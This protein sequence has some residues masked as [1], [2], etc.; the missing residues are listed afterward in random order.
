MLDGNEMAKGQS[1]FQF[2]GFE[3]SDNEEII[4]FSTDTISRR[5]YVLQFKNLNTGEIYPEK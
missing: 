3:V 5:N 1:Y 4:A 2:G